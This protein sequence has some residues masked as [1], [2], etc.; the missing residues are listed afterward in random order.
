MPDIWLNSIKDIKQGAHIGILGGAFDPPHLGHELLGLSFLAL[1]PIDELW[2]VPCANHATKENLSPFSH[3]LKM[4]RLAFE[5]LRN[6]RVLD[7]ENHLAT[8]NFTVQTLAAIKAARPDI[9]LYFG[10][11]SDL[12]TEFPKWHNAHEIVKL[13]KIVIFERGDFNIN[14]LPAVLENSPIHQG[15]VLPNVNSTKLRELLALN[16]HASQLI[17]REV[18]RYLK[19]HGLYKNGS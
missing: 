3:R 18:H 1:E 4:C 11:G 19:T 5:R 7:V 10:L 6:T 14:K 17:D 15:Y 16:H 2:I 12:I 9:F 13:A 8:P